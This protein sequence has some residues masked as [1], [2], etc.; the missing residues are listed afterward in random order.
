MA[1]CHG[2][3][4]KMA[5]LVAAFGSHLVDERYESDR[6]RQLNDTLFLVEPDFTVANIKTW[7][8]TL[9]RSQYVFQSG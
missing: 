6:V 7:E 8:N 3:R 5:P 2:S 9:S 4:V 1:N